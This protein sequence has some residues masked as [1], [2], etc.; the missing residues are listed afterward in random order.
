VNYEKF[1]KKAEEAAQLLRKTLGIEK[2]PPIA[3]ILGTGWGGKIEMKESVPFGEI[4]KHFH[5][6]EPIPGHARRIGLATVNGITAIVVSGRI[7]MYE[8]KPKLL[9][10]LMR[11]LWEFGCRKLLLTNAVGGIGETVLKGDIIVVQRVIK[12]CES[13]LSGARFTDSASLIRYGIARKI[14]ATSPVPMVH[15]GDIITNQGPEF[16]S[17][18][19]HRFLTCPGALGFG[20]SPYADLVCWRYFSDTSNL[21]DPTS[22][23]AVV[24]SCC[25]NGINDI[26]GHE[27]NVKALKENTDRLSKMLEHAVSVMSS[28]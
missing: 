22:V 24:I 6:L 21:S 12:N 15:F 5:K 4:S 13:P 28:E 17:P 1:N 23:C 26:H 20:M 16:E 8:K 10:F 7:H 27:N 25:S 2:S 18:S 9:Y 3:I 14:W 11:I 19:D